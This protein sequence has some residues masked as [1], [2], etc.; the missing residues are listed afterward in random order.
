MPAPPP[1]PM[2]GMGFGD[3]GLLDMSPSGAV[4]P[5]GT[6]EPPPRGSLATPVA[7]GIGWA[8]SQNRG[9]GHVDLSRNG[10]P[11]RGLP[12]GTFDNHVCSIQARTGGAPRLQTD[13]RV[14]AT[15]RQSRSLRHCPHASCTYSTD[16]GAVRL[17]THVKTHLHDRP[18][19]CEQCGKPFKT[20]EH[21]R[22]HARTHIELR[23]FT[24]DRPLCKHTDHPAFKTS[25]ELA[26]H[27][28]RTH[29][30]DKY[31]FLA[32]PN[33]DT[34]VYRPSLTVYC[35]GRGH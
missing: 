26:L 1:H 6:Q 24:C 13:D 34:Y 27:A 2:D 35:P 8:R 3:D 28:K 33:P 22:Q 25:I 12:M 16:Q 23:L 4:L 30:L 7:N 9:A 20:T 17:A 21:L 19:Q 29:T 5:V 31:V 32:F 10:H 11:A 15:K 14:T 18:H